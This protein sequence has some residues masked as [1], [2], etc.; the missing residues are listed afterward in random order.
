[1]GLRR[2]YE[3]LGPEPGEDP[4]SKSP[5]RDS[6]YIYIYYTFNIYIYIYIYYIYI[7]ID[8]YVYILLSSGF[9]V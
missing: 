2:G 5:P 4:D 9:R 6:I 7:Y 1:M 3:S 8:R